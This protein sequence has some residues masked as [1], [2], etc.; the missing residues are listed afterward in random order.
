MATERKGT[1][2]NTLGGIL[3][4]VI[5]AAVG[6]TVT[7]AEHAVDWFH[8]YQ[9]AHKG[10]IPVPPVGSKDFPV[11][12]EKAAEMLN[13]YGFKAIPMEISVTESSKYKACIDFRAVKSDPSQNSKVMLGMH[14]FQML[15]MVI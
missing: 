13:L 5:T 4:T 14:F 11:T 2:G 3:T 6:V 8:E 15:L 7:V 1:G 9:E 12:L 10:L